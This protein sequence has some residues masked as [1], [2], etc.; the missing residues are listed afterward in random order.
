MKGNYLMPAENNNQLPAVVLCTVFHA[1]AE[2]YTPY[3]RN[4]KKQVKQI[5]PNVELFADFRMNRLEVAK[6]ETHEDI[7]L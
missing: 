5:K 7:L 3:N 4:L 6:S 1:L 2:Y